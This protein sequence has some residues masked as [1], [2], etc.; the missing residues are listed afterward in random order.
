MKSK[1]TAYIIWFFLG[2]LGIHA[3][4][5]KKTNWGLFTLLTYVLA[6][7]LL[8]FDGGIMFFLHVVNVLFQA[9]FIPT[10]VK[11]ANQKEAQVQSDLIAEGIRKARDE[12]V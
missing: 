3:F 5:A 1:A 4:Y 12:D 11:E 2:G 8:V 10:W 6:L 9:F 7:S